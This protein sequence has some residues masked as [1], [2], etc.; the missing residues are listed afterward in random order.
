MA[1]S[2]SAEVLRARQLDEQ[3]RG[4][5]GPGASEQRRDARAL[6]RR[7]TRV[8]QRRGERLDRATVGDGSGRAA[9]APRASASPRTSGLR[10]A[11]NS[12]TTGTSALVPAPAS[13]CSA[14]A[15]GSTPRRM[16]RTSAGAS[17]RACSAPRTH[18]A[19]VAACGEG[20][21]ASSAR[22][23]GTAA[24]PAATSASRTGV[25]SSGPG[26]VVARAERCDEHPHARRASRCARARRAPRAA[27]RASE[28]PTKGAM[29]STA[30]AGAQAAER[31]ERV[32]P[33]LGVL[34][35]QRQHQRRRRP[36][37]AE[38]AERARPRPGARR[39]T[40]PRPCR[41]AAPR[42]ARRPGARAPR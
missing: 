4:A 41:R 7:W 14:A 20:E 39:A 9:R 21:P 33:H 3:R 22:S 32:A 31:R 11:T 34:I 5:R 40:S 27:A 38:V 18:A 37:V 13:A 29:A 36:R 1:A 10:S 8:A 25:G 6:A 12:S 2:R 30:S 23:D 28:S 24:A 19:L 42:R 15:V 26:V 17:L 35:A 16:A